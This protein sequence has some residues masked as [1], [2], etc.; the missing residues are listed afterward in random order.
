LFLLLFKKKRK[1]DLFHQKNKNKL[2]YY[3]M[4]FFNRTFIFTFKKEYQLLL[5][6]LHIVVKYLLNVNLTVKNNVLTVAMNKFF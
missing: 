6:T 5:F 2:N 3:L 4:F 1:F